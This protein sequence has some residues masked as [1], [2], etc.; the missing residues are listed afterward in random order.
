MN[1]LNNSFNKISSV[2]GK[3]RKFGS[4]VGKHIHNF[5]SYLTP[6]AENTPNLTGLS[7]TLA[8]ISNVA[9]DTNRPEIIDGYKYDSSL[10]NQLVA[11]YKN[12]QNIIL[13]FR[14]T[15]KFQD[16]KTDLEIVKGSSNDIQFREAE[17]IYQKVKNLYPNLNIIAT[18]HSKGG[19]LALHLNRLHNIRAEVFNPGVGFISSNPN[20]NNATLHVIKGDPISSLSGVKNIG[21]LNIYKSIYEDNHIK[22]HLIIIFI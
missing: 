16:L 20:S 13:G 10:S 14:G 6:K 1:I 12:D 21:K 11:V 18:G 19:S 7:R 9:Y 17:S 8:T 22:D 3:I 2:V 5:S 4:N 15:S